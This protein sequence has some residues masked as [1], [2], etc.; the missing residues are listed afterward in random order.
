MAVWFLLLSLFH[1]SVLAQDRPAVSCAQIT[2]RG[3]LGD[4]G[5]NPQGQTIKG[6]IEVPKKISQGYFHSSATKLN[7]E[8]SAFIGVE[9]IQNGGSHHYYLVV[10]KVR[11]DGNLLISSI[12]VGRE[13]TPLMSSGVLYQLD[14][15]SE[16]LQRLRRVVEK[17]GNVRRISCLHG[18]CRVLAKAEI[19]IE[20]PQGMQ[21]IRAKNFNRALLEGKVFDQGK[22]IELDAIRFHA[23]SDAQLEHFAEFVV[24]ADAAAKNEFLLDAF[25]IS[26]PIGATTICYLMV[27]EGMKKRAMNKQPKKEL[28]ERELIRTPLQAQ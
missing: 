1:L 14:L 8:G 16:T 2:L 4:L 27:D 24:N 25:L 11:Y 20:G 9:N 18:L 7:P 10:D 12:K 28:Q 22:Q 3:I 23:T 15:P 17:S 13:S 21:K 19:G 26:V 6:N 5:G